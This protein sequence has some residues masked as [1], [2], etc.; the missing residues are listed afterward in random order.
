MKKKKK[1]KDSSRDAEQKKKVVSIKKDK[2]FRCVNVKLHV[3]LAVYLNV[4]K[5]HV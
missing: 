5:K 1:K 4:N 2:K 3:V